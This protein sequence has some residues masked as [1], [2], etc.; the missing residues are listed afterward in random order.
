MRVTAENIAHAETPGYQ[1]REVL[2]EELLGAAQSASSLSLAR[3]QGAHLG[4]GDAAGPSIPAPRIVAA[5]RRAEGT[6]NGVDVERELVALQK[7][8]IQ[9]QALS[10]VLAD[11]YRAL[12]EAI[13]PS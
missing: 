8:E 2:F 5:A 3:T 10:Q 4:G 7:N 1:P 9:F 12:R 13:R 6:P 11:K